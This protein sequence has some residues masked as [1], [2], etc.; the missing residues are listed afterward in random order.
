MKLILGSKSYGRRQVLTDAG[1]NFSSMTA[2]IDERAIRS[3]DF[4]MLPLLVARAKAKALI[5]LIQEPAVLITA[6]TVVVWHGQLREKPVDAA[7]ATEFLSSYGDDELIHVNN[8]MV[9][10]NLVTGAQFEGTDASGVYLG[11]IPA[12]VIEKMVAGGEVLHV[13]GGFKMQ[14]PLL[15]PYMLGIQGTFESV[16]GLPLDLLEELLGKAGYIR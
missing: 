9:V 4:H 15:D 7:E 14:A 1:Y 8:G 10:T 2:D 13:A 11:K 16:V 12:D 6:D 5:P 3:T